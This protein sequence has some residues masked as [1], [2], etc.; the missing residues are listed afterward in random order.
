MIL[1]KQGKCNVVPPRWLDVTTLNT[2]NE[3]ERSDDVFQVN[4]GDHFLCEMHV[5]TQLALTVS[6]YLP[7]ALPFHYIELATDLCK[8]AREDLQ[9]WSL[10]YDLMV[11]FFF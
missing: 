1:K 9:D 11:S 6:I 2:V 4:D 7:Q 10:S 8:Y 3:L 5:C